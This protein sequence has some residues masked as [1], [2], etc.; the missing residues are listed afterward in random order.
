ME[1]D[2]VYRLPPYEVTTRELSA[3]EIAE[4]VDWGL[5]NSGVPEVWKTTQGY[6]EK[7]K[8]AV[9]LAILDTGIDENH[10]DIKDRLRSAKDFTGS[11]YGY[12]DKQSHGTHCA[13]IAL[14]TQNNKGVVGVAPRADLHVYKVLGDDGSGASSGIA[15]GI[16]QAVDDG[17]DVLSMSLG[18]AF[19]DQ[20]ILKA[21]KY[22]TDAG[23]IVVVAAGN[24]GM[25]DS[26]GWPG[27]S[28]LVICV[29]SYNKR[30][31]ISD[32]SSRGPEVDIAAPGE[33]IMSTIPGNKYAGMSGTSMATPFVAGACC[34][35]LAREWD[36][37][38][39]ATPIIV[40]GDKAN[41]YLRMLTHIKRAANEYG[42]PGQDAASGWGF[43]N[44]GKLVGEL[45]GGI[46]TPPPVG[47][48]VVISGVTVNGVP[49]SFVFKPN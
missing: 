8:K 31:E 38:S 45:T 25:D 40:P 28:E 20:R 41:N 22:A 30:G 36:L 49:G 11:R 10:D 17:C 5:A 9:T 37:E 27:R 23:C 14:A 29:A 12:V 24:D 33:N 26:V 35:A 4:L 43:L 13:G 15:K 21:I 18:S 46:I 1:R 34:L 6:S 47:G 2:P 48:Q 3:A 19:P 39:P 42:E 32:Y 7:K 16:A 44:P